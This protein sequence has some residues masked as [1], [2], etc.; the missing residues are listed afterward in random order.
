MCLVSIGVIGAV[1]RARG[2][3]AAKDDLRDMFGII[4][5][6]LDVSKQNCRGYDA[7]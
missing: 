2:D 1:N 4:R 3:Q 6:L 5:F 7:H